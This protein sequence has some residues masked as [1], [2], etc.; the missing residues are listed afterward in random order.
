M[1]LFGNTFTKKEI[2]SRVGSIKQLAGAQKITV[3]EGKGRNCT[4]IRVRNGL[5]LDFTIVPD[6][7]MDIFDAYY[8]GVPMAWVSRNGLVN[9]TNFDDREIGWLRSFNGGMLV[10]CGLRNVGSPCDTEGEHFGLHGRYTS[11]SAEN[12]NINQYWKNDQYFIEVSG[13]I[14]ESK[15]FGENLVCYRTIKVNSQN[16][17]IVLTDRIVNEGFKAEPLMLLYHFNW[18]YPLFSN[19][20]K[21]TISPKSTSVRGSN[22]P[23]AS[24]NEFSEPI[25]NFNEI[26]YLHE[27]EADENKFS[28]YQLQNPSTGIGVK[29]SWLKEQLPCFTQWKMTGEGEY[30]LGLEP[31][32]C[33]PNGRATEIEKGRGNVLNS[34][35]VKEVNIIIGFSGL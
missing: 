4:I 21:L 22:A 32:N 24:W 3:A 15:V 18:G 28:S 17:E 25:A 16:N 14:R 12:V 23:T 1:K 34:F 31:G 8:E 19:D 5:G 27:L 2:L 20:S 26:V 11:I 35:G 29:V 6:R 30:V 13:E 9:S 10:T 33:F 7:G